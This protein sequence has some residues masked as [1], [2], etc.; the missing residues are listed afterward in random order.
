MTTTTSIL[1]L[2]R[3]PE[4][5]EVLRNRCDIVASKGGTYAITTCFEGGEWITKYVINWPVLAKE[6]P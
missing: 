1:L 6:Q 2:N 5:H 4:T 3:Q